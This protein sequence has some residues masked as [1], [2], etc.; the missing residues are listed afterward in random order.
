MKA[1]N[2]SM[3]LGLVDDDIIEAANA[4]RGRKPKSHWMRY[5]A[6]AACL[7]L[8]ASVTVIFFRGFS[9]IGTK[10]GRGLGQ[11]VS[12]SY[13]YRTDFGFY[14]YTGGE[15]E[16][17]MSTFNVRDVGW[18][19]D[20]NG[21]YFIKGRSLY[22]RE[23]DTGRQ[24]VLYTAESE[25]YFRVDRVSSEIGVNDSEIG[26]G[27]VDRNS[28]YETPYRDLDKKTGEVVWQ[29]NY[30]DL[31]NMPREYPVGD[32]VFTSVYNSERSEDGGYDLYLNGESYFTLSD[33]EYMETQ[34]TYCGK[35][36]LISYHKF[37]L[38]MGETPHGE[39]WVYVASDEGYILAKLD[40]EIISIPDGTYLCGTDDY[41]FYL[42]V[43]SPNHPKSQILY[44][45]SA[46]TRETALLYNGDDMAVQN[47]V[48][49]GIWLFTNVPS[50]RTD[51]WKLLYSADGKLTGLELFA[52]V[53]A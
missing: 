19:V 26:V 53:D 10:G 25:L 33:G 21:L 11:L 52:I 42:G 22:V 5:T 37:V 47:A 41:L 48:T 17:L 3:A 35:N 14:R 49:D 18:F 24:R 2:I 20:E 29:G 40:G 8:I 50:G 36:L 34:L 1:E 46:K 27:L 43:E 23:N 44:S 4:V 28:E 30:A 38:T 7:C 32:N 6:L 16:R 45:Y 12:G 51:C 9:I 31:K 15:R 13:Y 39:D